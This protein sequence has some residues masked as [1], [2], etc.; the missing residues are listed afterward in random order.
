MIPQ[1]PTVHA[2][3]EEQAAA[4]PDAVVFPNRALTYRQLNESANRLA[5]R[6]IRRG[7]TRGGFV[8]LCMERS[9]EVVVGILGILKAGAAYV[10]IDPAYPAERIDFMLRD[11]AARVVLTHAP[12]ADRLTSLGVETVCLDAEPSA[13]EPAPNPSTGSSAD[14][15]VYVMYT[16]G[17]TGRPK[18]VLVCHRGV[19]RL[20]RETNYCDFGPNEVFLLHSPLTFDASTFEI[21]GPLL[22]GGQL[23]ILPPGPPAPDVLASAIRRFGV[24]TLWL[25]A[26]LF[27][28][29]VE[30]RPEEL[31]RV[32]QLVAGGD[33]LSPTHVQ[34]ALDAR[35]SGV[36]VNGYG[37]TETTTFAC[38]FRMTRD[39]RPTGTIPIG[40][41]IANTTVYVLNEAMQ[42]VAE[43]ASGELFIGGPGVAAG[44]LNQPELT[45]EKF[46]PDRF[47]EDPSAK[48]YR[49]GDR[50][51]VRPD[52][53][54]E[55]LGRLDGQ[56]KI[57]G[58][59]I[60]PEEVEAALRLHPAVRQVAVAAR[61]LPS[62]EKQLLAYAV[63]ADPAA[64]SADAIK[65]DLTT[66]LARYLIPAQ[67]IRLDALPLTPNG[68]V[69]RAALM[70]LPAP[71][72]PAAPAAPAV[73]RTGTGIEAEVAAIWAGVLGRA[74][75]ADDNFFDLGGTSLQLLETHAI[76]TRSLDRDIPLME[77]F[78]HPTVQ[79]LA[80]HLAGAGGSEPAVTAAQDRARR[81]KEALLAR[82]RKLS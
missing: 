71:E 5:H 10:P 40:P 20:V 17:S 16:S 30:Q 65:R 51:R 78:E 59:R 13:D 37:P 72:Q 39:F 64:F 3:F 76:L 63:A 50:V 75:G 8:G 12:T 56:V 18:G 74:V 42:P 53:A 73:P 35:G 2:R 60:E 27:H 25:T 19:I 21:W 41:P 23:A 26:G 1:S 11:S 80:R 44:Y 48:L 9:P 82:R 62:G 32:R 46:V 31:A 6:L 24:T 66:R 47:G 58:H 36:L 7:V 33:V 67:V 28:L 68:K 55:F 38:C 15:P 14:D 29:M 34:K 52:G 61:P 81:Q 69:D 45:R 22:N 49:T 4:T 54:I 77:L 43:G 70:A 57:A 79:S